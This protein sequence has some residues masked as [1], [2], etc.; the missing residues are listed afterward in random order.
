[1]VLSHYNTVVGIRDR[2]GVKMKNKLKNIKDE[3]QQ[4]CTEVSASLCAQSAN[5]E[6]IA[7]VTPPFKT[8]DDFDAWF[9]SDAKLVLRRE[10]R[11]GI[12]RAV[13]FSI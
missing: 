7:E 11:N 10:E 9:N 12:P 13:S 4:I 5:L 1:M 3:S 6:A 8:L 2:R